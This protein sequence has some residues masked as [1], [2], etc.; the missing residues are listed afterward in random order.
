MAAAPDLERRLATAFDRAFR[1]R[2]WGVAG[3]VAL[4]TAGAWLEGR[5][6]TDPL[7]LTS[8]LLEQPD[9]VGKGHRVT[10]L[11]AELLRKE[12]RREVA[13]AVIGAL[14]ARSR[15]LGAEILRVA[16]ASLAA[17]QGDFDPARRIVRQE[18][19]IPNSAWAALFRARCARALGL[20][21]EV[22]A[23]LAHVRTSPWEIWLRA[24]LAEVAAPPLASGF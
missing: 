16:R 10:L 4:H 13:L 24:A 2:M 5:V 15:G 1:A 20:P 23:S 14:E 21:Q 8:L 7:R 3:S 11:H 22:A 9:L 18:G 6:S 17:E 19:R 12:G